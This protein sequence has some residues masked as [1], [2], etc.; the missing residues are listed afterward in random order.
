L[1]GIKKSRELL[2]SSYDII[3][4]YFHSLK[5]FSVDPNGQLQVRG[6]EISESELLAFTIW[7]QQ[8]TRELKSFVVGIGKLDI[9]TL[10]AEISEDLEQAGFY[11][12]FRQAA[13]LKY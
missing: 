1:I 10:T 5:H 13:E 7:I 2:Q 3:L 11:E 9:H 12:Y 6:E 8:F 4:P